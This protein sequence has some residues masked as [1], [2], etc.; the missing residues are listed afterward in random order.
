MQDAG[1]RAVGH[2]VVQHGGAFFPTWPSWVYR[3][4]CG[5]SLMAATASA[6]VEAGRHTTL[7]EVQEE[8][9]KP[10]PTSKVWARA[11][12]EG[13]EISDELFDMAIQAVGVGIG[14][15]VSLLTSN[16]S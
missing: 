14:S 6:M 15:M 10:R 7:F 4:L 2:V 9:R 3:S 5:P 16:T 13:D 11:L 8:L 12:E 1:P